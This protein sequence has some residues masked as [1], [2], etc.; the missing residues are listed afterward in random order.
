MKRYFTFIGMI[1]FI[2]LFLAVG[3]YIQQEQ[4]QQLATQEMY[5]KERHL[6][7]YS[8]MPTAV[9]RDLAEA[10][11]KS[12]H[13]RVQMVSMSEDGLQRALQKPVQGRMTPDGR[14]TSSRSDSGMFYSLFIGGDGNGT[15]LFEGR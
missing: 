3:V 1:V 8:D 6:V 14:Y 5:A 13:L 7:V 12:K 9:N 15:S 2:G 4:Q 10:F 11:Y